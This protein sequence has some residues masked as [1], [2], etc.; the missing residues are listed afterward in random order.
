MESPDLDYLVESIPNPVH[1]AGAARDRWLWLPPTFA[2]LCGAAGTYLAYHA[3]GLSLG[4]FLGG[5]FW[6]TL[7]TAP[8]AAG[9]KTWLGQS[10]VAVGMILGVAGVWIFVATKTAFPIKLVALSS[11]VLLAYTLA[12]TALTGFIS[13]GPLARAGG[14]I[15]TLLALA[16]FFWP[17]WLSP[18]LSQPQGQRLV[19]WLVPCH[20]V[21]SVNAVLLP[22]LGYWAEQ[23]IAYHYTSLSDDVS[24][25]LPTSVLPCVALHGCIAISAWLLALVTRRRVKAGSPPA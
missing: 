11:A 20:P 21:F 8:L 5:I 17:I 25:S 6:V 10:L 7:L 4:L 22:K 3:A 2:L 18:A 1:G 19:H 13:R 15:V 23:S 12:I 16:W 9:E 24:Y 14:A